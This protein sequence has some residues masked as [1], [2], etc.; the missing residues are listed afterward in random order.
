M[1]T[2]LSYGRT[3]KPCA[4]AVIALLASALPSFAQTNSNDRAS[5]PIKFSTAPLQLRSSAETNPRNVMTQSAAA[6]GVAYI[7]ITFGTVIIAVVALE[8]SQPMMLSGSNPAP[9]RFAETL[10]GT[11]AQKNFAGE[12]SLIQP[13]QEPRTDRLQLTRPRPRFSLG[14]DETKRAL[15]TEKPPGWVLLNVRF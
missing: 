13:S 9:I 3:L 8:P 1:K 4:W 14:G 10:S 6:P 2:S 5:N 12:P 11:A 7:P 15:I